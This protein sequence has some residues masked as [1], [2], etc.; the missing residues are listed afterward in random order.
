MR[1]SVR[2]SIVKPADQSVSFNVLVACA[3][4]PACAIQIRMLRSHLRSR[5]QT[6]SSGHR[7]V[8][9][10]RTVAAL[11]GETV[12]IVCASLIYTGFTAW[13]TVTRA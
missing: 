13:L 4:V 12:A 7:G 3:F 10:D 11:I 1:S 6:S 2:R 8:E 9:T 5:V